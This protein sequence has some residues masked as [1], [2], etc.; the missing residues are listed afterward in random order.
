LEFFDVKNA[1]RDLPRQAEHGV[2]AR[3]FPCCLAVVPRLL[4]GDAW[5]GVLC[6]GCVGQVANR[7]PV[8]A[9]CTRGKLLQ[10]VLWPSS[11][12]NNSRPSDPSSRGAAETAAAAAAAAVAPS[13]DVVV[14]SA[15]DSGCWNFTAA[16][17]PTG[18]GVVLQIRA[19]AAP[20]GHYT[21]A[22]AA[23]GAGS[24][25]EL[26]VRVE[27]LK[28]HGHGCNAVGDSTV[29]TL[30]LNTS[31]ATTAVTCTSLD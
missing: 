20:P 13:T 16:G 25:F 10:A 22:A 7:K 21:I 2:R 18:V 26:R 23:P 4:S 31:G 27:S 3:V 9:V 11:T 15:A 30:K 28:L 6:C 5:G 24:A 17:P 8:Q 12:S 29:V 19:A 1:R 14:V